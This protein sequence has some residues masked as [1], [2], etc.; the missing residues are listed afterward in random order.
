MNAGLSPVAS[1]VHWAGRK[2]L[3]DLQAAA[4]LLKY[5]RRVSTIVAAV[6]RCFPERGTLSAHVQGGLPA[7]SQQA[8]TPTG[9]ERWKSNPGSS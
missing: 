5:A 4:S 2:R 1:A 8:R 7:G 9:D 6:H 3:N